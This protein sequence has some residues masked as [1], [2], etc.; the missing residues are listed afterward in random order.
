[1]QSFS[2]KN[3]ETINPMVTSTPLAEDGAETISSEIVMNAVQNRRASVR[4]E[5][6]QTRQMRETEYLNSTHKSEA[7]Y[8]YGEYA[9]KPLPDTQGEIALPVELEYNFPKLKEKSQNSLF[10]RIKILLRDTHIPKLEWSLGNCLVFIVYLGINV[11]C[12]LLSPNKDYGLWYILECRSLVFLSF[13]I[14]YL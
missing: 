3:K 7:I 2:S 5:K 9:N 11:M 10:R 12:L 13:L 1:M 4:E 6:V 14:C 8:D